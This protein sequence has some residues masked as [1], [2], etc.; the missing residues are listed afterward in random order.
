VTN[1]D[2]TTILRPES[3]DALYNSILSSELESEVWVYNQ[4]ETIKQ[5]GEDNKVVITIELRNGV[6]IELAY[7]CELKLVNAANYSFYRTSD[8][9]ERLIGL[10]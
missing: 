2:I 3:I 10:S 9:F 5:Q 7:Y 1:G 8:D 6:L 4:A